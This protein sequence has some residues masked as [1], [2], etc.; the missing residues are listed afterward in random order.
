MG[1]RGVALVSRVM[2]IVGVCISCT[3]NFFCVL[4][5]TKF[6]C[7]DSNNLDVAALGSVQ[8]H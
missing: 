6:N 7:R 2:G 1:V 8:G 5:A 4:S 3:L